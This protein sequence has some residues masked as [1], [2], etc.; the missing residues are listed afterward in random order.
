MSSFFSKIALRI[1]LSHPIQAMHAWKKHLTIRTI[2]IRRRPD[3]DF[4]CN[5]KTIHLCL[6]EIF[7]PQNGTQGI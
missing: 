5:V 3:P 1:V 7:W 6:L 2:I 4:V